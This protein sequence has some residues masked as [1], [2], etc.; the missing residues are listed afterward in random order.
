MDGLRADQSV[1]T[2]ARVAFESVRRQILYG[3]LKPGAKI[4]QGLVAEQLA[5]SLVP[6]REA[7]R[8]LEASGLVRIV[9]HR[10]AFV[11]PVS[12]DEF[13]QIHEIL[14]VLEELA[15]KYATPRLTDEAVDQLDRLTV[16]MEQQTSARN[17]ARL[18][19]LNDQFHLTIYRASG[20]PLLFEVISGLW[21][22]ALRYRIRS[23]RLPGRDI[24]ALNEHK[25][26]MQALRNRLVPAAV[27]AMRTHIRRHLDALE[28]VFDLGPETEASPKNSKPRDGSVVNVG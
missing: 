4:N 18:L 28:P 6:L 3:E 26:I 17:Y 11:S 24:Q 13:T 25:E 9:P 2:L 23:V 27:R 14:I 16:E 10:G 8:W 5:I 19:E 22:K 20:R 15:T 7:L 21:D 1:R 12:G